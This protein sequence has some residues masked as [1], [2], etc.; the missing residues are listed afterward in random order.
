MIRYTC[1]RCQESLESPESQAGLRETCP[2]CGDAV[3]VP[4]RRPPSSPSPTE[5]ENPE[6]HRSAETKACPYCGE[7]IKAVA[8]KCKHCGEMFEGV[9]QAPSQDLRAGRVDV[10]RGPESVIFE[11]RGSQWA[12][13]GAYVGCGVLLVCLGSLFG[14]VGIS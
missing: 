2:R 8:I 6:A 14:F 13:L 1:P 9:R 11:G 10:Q 7:T 3:L 5:G 12:N 4:N